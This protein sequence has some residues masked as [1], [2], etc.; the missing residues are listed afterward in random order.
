M[1]NYWLSMKKIL[2]LTRKDIKHPKSGGAEVVIHEYMKWLAQKWY[3]V[4]QI[5][6]NFTDS[7]ASEIVDGV[8]IKRIFTIHT[9]Y[10]LFWAYYLLYLQGKY[11]LI[12]DHAWWI[13]LLSP[14][15]E[16]RKKIVFFTHHVW[17]KERSEYFH[18]WIW[19]WRIGS[20]FKWI[21]NIFV[22]WL[23]K[24]KLTIT[25]SEWTAHELKK[26][27]FTNI[28]VLKNTTN[29]SIIDKISEK[30]KKIVML[31][32]VVPNKRID[33][34]IYVVH[35]LNELWYNY[36]LDIIGNTQ[37]KIEYKRLSDITHKLWCNDFVNF[38]GRM[39]EDNIKSLLQSAEYLLITSEKEGFGIVVLEANTQGTPA[40]W[41]NIPGINEAISENDNGVLFTQGDYQSIA[42]YI[43]DNQSQYGLLQQ[44]TL[45][46]I[47]SYPTRIVNVNHME[48]ILL[49]L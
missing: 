45:K 2:F 23:Y 41:Y 27:W 35:R 4:T 44:S 30:Q 3:E 7:L 24:K 1:F 29:R 22:L 33:H 15:Y 5:A 18:Q 25:V 8:T 39:S 26:L 10:F 19:M 40:L 20:M 38:H 36:K 9:I 34:W 13:P 49:S 43:I 12:V 47:T 14:L 46:Y 48:Q 6:P 11:D 42:Q 32:R 28:K 37:D 16:R 17:T 31:W 21:Y